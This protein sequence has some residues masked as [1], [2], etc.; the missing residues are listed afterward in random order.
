MKFLKQSI[1]CFV[2]FLALNGF[3]LAGTMTETG[4]AYG[5][6]LTQEETVLPDGNVLTRGTDQSIWVQ[7]GVPE[8]FPSMLMGNCQSMGLRSPE[9]ANLGFTWACTATDIDG[10][11]FINLGGDANPDWSGCNYKSVAGWGKYA[12]VTRSG[13]CYFAG[14]VTADGSHWVLK[15]S[16][17]TTY[18]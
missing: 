10:D 15:W 1:V 16:G 9:F 4:T 3:V 6:T 8:G 12:G 18:P 13:T 2:A 14:N 11:G 5:T 17:E 7:E